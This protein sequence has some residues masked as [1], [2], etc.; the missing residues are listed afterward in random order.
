MSKILSL[1]GCMAVGKT[2]ALKYIQS[3]APYVNVSFEDKKHIAA[4]A[5][6]LGLD[7]NVFEDYI[8]IQKLWIQNEIIRC[9]AVQEY[10]CTVMDFGAEEI[11]FYSFAYPRTIGADWDV[12]SALHEQLEELRKYLPERIL[13][14]D[15]SEK[16]LRSHKENDK[17]G[18]RRS[19]EFYVK[20]IMP[21][22][23]EWFIGRSNVDVIDVDDMEKERMCELVL[24]W[25]NRYR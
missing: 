18:T 11:E 6:K 2:T 5:R 25:V 4:Q 19:F 16:T 21:I 7:K 1:Q 8:E 13:Y 12:E 22:K 24:E 3:H 14:L 10:E 15:A 20:H 9:E 17:P 23:R